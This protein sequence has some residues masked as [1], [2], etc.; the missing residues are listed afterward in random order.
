MTYMHKGNVM[1]VTGQRDGTVEILRMRVKT[2]FPPTVQSEI[3]TG[4]LFILRDS[5]D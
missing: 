3:L 5:N 4:S 1:P 2:L